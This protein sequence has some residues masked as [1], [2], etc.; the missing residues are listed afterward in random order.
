MTHKFTLHKLSKGFVVISD[1]EIKEKEYCKVFNCD[2]DGKV[3][4][5]E[6]IDTDEFGNPIFISPHNEK[7]T[8][9]SHEVFAGEYKRYSFKKVIA[10]QDEIDFSVLSEEEQKKIG[11]I[12]VEKLA[13]EFAPVQIDDYDGKFAEYDINENVRDGVKYGFQ[14]AL[15]FLSDK[16]FTLEDME[17]SW[18][19][20]YH[21]KVD[22]LHGNQLRYFEDCI[23]SLSKPNSWEVELEMEDKI[24]LAGNTVIGKE[25]KLSNG[26]IKIVKVL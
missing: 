19:A 5:G 4:L 17:K 23:Q 25:P 24:A 12:D 3:G 22:E 20:G 15:E 18:S 10:L 16:M 1:E 7:I 26:K 6:Y 21:R 9:D 2:V 13:Y 8:F 14:K 11:W